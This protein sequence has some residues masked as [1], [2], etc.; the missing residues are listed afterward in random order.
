MNGDTLSTKADETVMEFPCVELETYEMIHCAP[1][2]P[3]PKCPEF[4]PMYVEMVLQMKRYITADRAGIWEDHL[5]EV[6]NMIP[7][8]ISA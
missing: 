8:I 2:S 3:V 7:F 5:T 1:A 6:T 4:W